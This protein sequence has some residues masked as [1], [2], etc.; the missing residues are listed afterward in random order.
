MEE[1]SEPPTPAQRLPLNVPRAAGAANAAPDWFF[2]DAPAAQ[3]ALNRD[4]ELTR[5]IASNLGDGV[6]AVDETGRIIF[7]N[8]V[9]AQMLGRDR[10]ALLDQSLYPLLDVGEVR[11][12]QLVREVQLSGRSARIDDAALQRDGAPNLFVSLSV[13]PLA[14]GGHYAGAVFALHDVTERRARVAALEHKALH[15]PL[16]ELPNRVLFRDRLQQALL[17]A[18]RNGGA[19]AVLVLDLN[20]FKAVN[21][22][23]GHHVGDILLQQVGA[24][25]QLALRASDTV[26]RFGGDEFAVLLPD[27][28]GEGALRAAQQV[29]R[30]IEHPF[31]VE[32]CTVQV[33][34]SIGIAFAPTHGTDPLLLL[35][36]ADAAM[37]AAKST[38]GGI[39]IYAV[40]D[41][42]R[43]P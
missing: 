8:P 29:R 30:A 19:T 20:G 22:R 5:A 35:R 42:A 41:E 24:R 23:L 7:A 15:D 31:T 34:A 1:R 13:A 32:G 27:A 21:D 37:Y 14:L 6:V 16:T 33:G 28:D 10:A 38:R 4:L 2:R 11:L 9:A 12:A 25:T 43:L 18:R 17:L 40:G 39:A 36:G 26:A 3:A